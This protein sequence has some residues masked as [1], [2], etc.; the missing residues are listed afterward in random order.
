VYIA[1]RNN[2]PTKLDN[3]TD[4]DLPSIEKLRDQVSRKGISTGGYWNPEDTL[5]YLEEPAVD[6]SKSRLSPTQ[7]RLD[8]GAGDS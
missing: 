2:D 7:S 5:Q 1:G 8:N 4:D 3:K 6:T